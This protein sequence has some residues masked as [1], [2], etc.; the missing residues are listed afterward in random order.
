MILAEY[1]VFSITILG[2]FSYC[3]FANGQY[4]SM[5]LS[6]EQAISYYNTM[7]TQIKSVDG[8]QDTM[9]VAFKGESISDKT[10]YRND[11]MST[12][13]MSGRDDALADAY[14]KLYLLKYYCGFDAEFIS[15][16][17][18]SSAAQEEIANMPLYPNDGSV[19]VIDDVVVVKI[20]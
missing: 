8:Y 4:L 13:S 6:Y 1:A 12:F 15:V 3:H 17:E 5:N 9:K 16:E 2:I 7:I 20:S 14:S 19:K 11:V 18:M 10:L